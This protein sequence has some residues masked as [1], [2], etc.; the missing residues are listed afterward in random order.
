V[1]L[2]LDLAPGAYRVRAAKHPAAAVLHAA[3]GATLPAATTVALHADGARV[4]ASTVA[5]GP[6]RLDV[7]NA[8]GRDVVAVVERT[9]WLDDVA[10]ALDVVALPGYAD[11]F[12]ADVLAPG[13]RIAVRRVTILFSDLRGSTALYRRVGDAAAYALVRDHFRAVRAAIRAHHGMFVKTIGDAVMASF[14]TP[15]AAV[16]A[17]VD[18]HRAVGRLAVPA[19]CDP[20]VLKTGVHEG[21]SIVVNA[22]GLLDFFGTTTNLAARAQHE[23]RGG[24]VILSAAVAADEDVARVLAD[25]P[26]AAEAFDATLKGFDAPIPLRRVTWT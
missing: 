22:G 16:A 1:T 26:H 18:M 3:T 20:L 17:A 19:G 21:P 5:A 15:A 2:A 6:V 11:L 7:T 8:D 10:T 23:A 13:E 9:A 4:G 24:D 12:T 14:R 25:V